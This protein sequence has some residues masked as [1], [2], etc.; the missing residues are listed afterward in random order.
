M[1]SSILTSSRCACLTEFTFI[2]SF[3]YVPLFQYNQ[4]GFIL[5]TFQISRFFGLTQM[6]EDV[7]S[8]FT[9]FLQSGK[10]QVQDLSE[11]SLHLIHITLLPFFAFV[12]TEMTSVKFKLSIKKTYGNQN[13][14]RYRPTVKIKFLGEFPFSMCHQKCPTKL[15]FSDN[16]E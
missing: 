7:F 13:D 6:W 9:T 4:Q 3:Y 10:W 15:E 5:F 11:V 12:V 1:L 14:W 16:P 2:F 8:F